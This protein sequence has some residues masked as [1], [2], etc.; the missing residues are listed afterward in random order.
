M[1]FYCKVTPR[2]LV[3][4]ADADWESK[5]RLKADAEVMVRVTTP[6]NIKFHRKFFALLRVTLANLPEEIE[7]RMHISSI[8]ALL[9]AIKIDM[10]YYDTVQ[11][12]GRS[13]V[14]LKSI[15][16]GKMD[17]EAFERF[18]DLA[19]TD[20]LNNYLQGTDRNELLQEAN[21]YAGVQTGQ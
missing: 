5:K 15:S 12:A 3:P 6:R 4:L 10:G 7:Q 20:I 19:V 2:G 16:F 9:A 8:D 11:V 17:E 21:E 13:V 1:E 14:R 18:Y